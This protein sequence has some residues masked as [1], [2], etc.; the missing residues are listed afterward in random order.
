MDWW[1]FLII[2][3]VVAP[4]IGGIFHTQERV[5]AFQALGDI[6][7]MPIEKIIAAVGQPNSVSAAANGNQLYQW[8]QQVGANAT[9]YAILVD[10]EGKAIG[11]T[12]Q[13]A[14]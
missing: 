1:W 7:G 14:A 6:G 8:V 5:N 12:H 10:T 11:F 9:H 13:F 3:L 4:V 2:A